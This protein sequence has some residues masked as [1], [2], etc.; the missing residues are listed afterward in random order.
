MPKHSKQARWQDRVGLL[1][2]LI[3]W[4]AILVPSY[5]YQ[6]RFVQSFGSSSWAFIVLVAILALFYSYIL[7]LHPKTSVSVITSLLS[8]LLVG[9][10]FATTNWR[11]GLLALAQCLLFFL[12]I[13]FRQATVPLIDITVYHIIIPLFLSVIGFFIF[14]HFFSSTFTLAV[15]L[16]LLLTAASSE[17]ELSLN[18]Q[19][20]I[21]A[22]LTL[23]LL[24][25]IKI[26][27]PVSVAP[28]IV[29]TGLTLAE[30]AANHFFNFKKTLQPLFYLLSI[31]LLLLI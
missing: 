10:L 11:L 4:L 12:P 13:F 18:W 2:P 3:A 16:L 7:P 9:I 29:V 25:L 27:L 15:L 14:T 17:I 6:H 23:I 30:V 1:N 22:L 31:L 24:V 20:L 28:F 8:L 21:L 26:K 19:N 5:F